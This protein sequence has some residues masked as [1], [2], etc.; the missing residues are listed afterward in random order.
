MASLGYNAKTFASAANFLMS[1][2][3]PETACLVADVNM[4]GMGGPE[5]HRHLV[6]AGLAIPTILITAYPDDRIR[7]DALKHGVLRYLCKLV[8]D[9][10]LEECVRSALGAVR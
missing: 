8:D 3:H 9:Q 10:D 1:P 5:L 7:N 4:P 6:D 2:L